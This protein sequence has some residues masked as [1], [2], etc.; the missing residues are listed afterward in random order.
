M[1]PEMARVPEDR[2]V[3]HGHSLGEEHEVVVHVGG[4]SGI[5]QPPVLYHDG[6]LSHVSPTASANSQCDNYYP[7]KSSTSTT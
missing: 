6:R 3:V 2:G 7:R 4:E 5:A 1:G